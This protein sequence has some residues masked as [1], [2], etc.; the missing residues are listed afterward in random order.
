MSVVTA[1]ATAAPS[2]DTPPPT[3]LLEGA[4]SLI[5]AVRAIR[6][7]EPGLGVK[8]LV[9]RLRLQPEL[10]GCSVGAKEVRQALRCLDVEVAPSAAAPS[11]AAP[12]DPQV[13]QR[14][15]CASCG[16]QVLVLS[17]LRRPQFTKHVLLL[18]G[19]LIASVASAQGLAQAAE[20]AR[21]EDEG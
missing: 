4:E 15:A 14:L 11:A 1:A 6:L 3:R 7:A 10:G 9:A 13:V 19:V 20:E 8:P 21:P 2:P 12:S 17:A 16:N 5:D 18:Q